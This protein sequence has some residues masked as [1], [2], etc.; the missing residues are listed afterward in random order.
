MMK[1]H[2]LDNISNEYQINIKLKFTSLYR[3]IIVLI[4]YVYFL[5]VAALWRY[6]LRGVLR[7]GQL[8]HPLVYHGVRLHPDI[9]RC[10]GESEKGDQE[11]P[12]TET[13]G[14][15]N[16]INHNMPPNIPT[17]IDTKALVT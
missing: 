2:R 1:T 9:L 7:I 17:E 15:L 12:E 4:T 3:Q 13:T 11:E 8:L 10:Q 5:F 14:I 6:R 16:N